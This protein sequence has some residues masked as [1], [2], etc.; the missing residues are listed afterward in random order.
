MRTRASAF[1]FGGRVVFAA[2][3]ALLAGG[4]AS[5]QT[6]VTWTNGSGDGNYSNA[7]NWNPNVV[8]IN[9]G[10]ATYTVV[11]PANQT[12]SIDFATPASMEVTDFSLGS[13][14]RFIL[15]PGRTYTVL[16]DA[17][18]G[19][20][21]EADGAG[22]HFS[23]IGPG[24]AVTG[25]AAKFAATG[26][27]QISVSGSTYSHR[28]SGHTA[29]MSATNAG[30]R[31]NVGGI[32]N[33]VYGAGGGRWFQS[34]RA[35]NSGVVD[36][37][38]LQSLSIV[39]NEDDVL[40]FVQ[41][42][43]GSIDLSALQSIDALGNG[44]GQVRFVADAAVFS[45]PS[46]MTANGV[47]LSPSAA[48]TFSM[49]ALMTLTNSVVS[50]A[51]GSVIDAPSLVDATNTNFT[52]STDR[53]F[54]T[55]LLSQIDGARIAVQG[56]LAYGRV[57]DAELNHTRAGH[58]T[59]L[60][61]TDPGSVF[62]L[63][64]VNV[65]NY[66]PGGGRWFQVIQGSNSGVVNLSN[67]ASIN[68]A[69]NED[70]VLDFNVGSGGSIDLSG[71]QSVN[72]AGNGNA[73]ARFIV[74]EPS[75]SLPS[76]LTAVG[77]QFMPANGTTIDVPFLTSLTG[78]N[79]DLADNSAVNAPSLTNVSGT[80]F[81]VSPA[82]SFNTGLLAQIDNA[83]IGVSG[84]LHYAAVSD[85]ALNHTRAG[86][87]TIL[88][89]SDPGSTFDARSIDSIAYG[90]GGGRWFSSVRA[91]NSGVLDFSGLTNVS[92]RAGEDDVFDFVADTGGAID[93][94][95][96]QTAN[97][98]SG[99]A[100]A[101]LRFTVS[102]GGRMN[103]GNLEIA[104]QAQFSIT[105]VSSTMD[106]AG[107]MLLD[108][109][110]LTIS[111]GATLTVGGDMTFRYTTET[112]LAASSARLHLNGNHAYSDPQLFEIGGMDAGNVNPGNSGNFGFGQLILG[113]VGSPTVVQLLDVID[114]G[115]RGGG[116]LVPEGL[117]LFG[118]GGPD[119]L[120]LRGGSILIIDNL[121]VYTTENNAWVHINSLFPPG[122]AM[123]PY[124]DG[125][126]ELP[127]PG[128]AAFG[129]GLGVLILAR[130]RARD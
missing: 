50:Q 59:I 85:T 92:I 51:A 118:L 45:L 63:T 122:V 129:V 80:D 128:G 54:N 19:G 11:I 24:A 29:F 1:A 55:G 40:D 48:T 79:V 25:T 43:G 2:V 102:N 21:I 35:S 126:I 61:A 98:G 103:F 109:G 99:N 123:I 7:L 16:D 82:R 22:T 112:N 46:L 18:V 111:A 96:L 12:V 70:D 56:G 64:S 58:A 84:G 26:G 127:A 114:N 17:D 6:I 8:P 75:Y 74:S 68:V 125:F 5:A 93:L 3:V 110:S 53:T 100:N 14:A 97:A 23:A 49:P 106:V 4:A 87:N 101:L 78:G 41:E 32:D 42:T 44:N 65:I 39:S 107:N 47:A 72:F 10:L 104:R 95:G 81:A 13:G 124:G 86:H 113:E 76:L 62:D 90:P 71:L 33:I 60:S 130:R 9:A 69:G 52:V 89:V 38:G 94:T 34:I 105:D 117:Y 116:G 37:S 119:G 77:A 108:S 67:L 66:G 36:L 31:L 91:G 115:N 20:S 15:R 28:T 88:S 30:S 57:I 27:A 83:L 120:I 121:N 73:R